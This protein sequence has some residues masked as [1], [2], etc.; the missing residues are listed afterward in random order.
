MAAHAWALQKPATKGK[1]ML[2][3][4]PH[5]RA[6]TSTPSLKSTTPAPFHKVPVVRSCVPPQHLPICLLPLLL[7]CHQ[8]PPSQLLSA[9]RWGRVLQLWFPP[10]IGHQCSSQQCYECKESFFPPVSLIGGFV[11]YLLLSKNF[12]NLSYR[13]NLELN[14]WTLHPVCIMD[15]SDSEL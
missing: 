6:P 5:W 9:P 2:G 7:R 11:L 8:P 3:G 1:T 15:G 10:D 14:T 4:S 12:W 13:E